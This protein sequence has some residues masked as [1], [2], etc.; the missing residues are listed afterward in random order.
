MLK[1]LLEPGIA[2]RVAD[3]PEHA[4]LSTELGAHISTA[5]SLKRIADALEKL[6]SVIVDEEMEQRAKEPAP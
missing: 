5:I 1:D 2:T 6:C 4:R 3:V